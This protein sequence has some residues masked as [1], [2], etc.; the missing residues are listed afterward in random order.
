MSY[1][2]FTSRA[3][4]IFKHVNCSV[5]VLDQIKILTLFCFSFITHTK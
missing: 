4:C 1:F 2:Y 5:L 3:W